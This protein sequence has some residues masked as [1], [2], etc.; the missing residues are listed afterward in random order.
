MAID[1]QPPAVSQKTAEFPRTENREPRTE[2]RWITSPYHH[3]P[4]VFDR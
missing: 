3:R 1:D 2:S 4:E